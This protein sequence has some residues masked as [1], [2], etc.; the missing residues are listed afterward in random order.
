MRDEKGS[1][2]A[3]PAVSIGFVTDPLRS[4]PSARSL[5]PVVPF[6]PARSL[7]PYVRAPTFAI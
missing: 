5:R 2:A 6:V 3:A 1:V 7:S 4:L